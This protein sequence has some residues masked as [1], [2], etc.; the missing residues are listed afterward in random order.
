MRLVI[1]VLIAGQAST[2]ERE[3]K[4]ALGIPSH[5]RTFALI[6]VGYR[7]GRFGHVRRKRLDEL[8]RWQHW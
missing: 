1:P 8:I 6:P 2:A 5:T 3:F 7:S 4:L